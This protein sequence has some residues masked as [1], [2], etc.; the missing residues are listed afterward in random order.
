MR[1]GKTM[2]MFVQDSYYLTHIRTG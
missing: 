2:K 1:N